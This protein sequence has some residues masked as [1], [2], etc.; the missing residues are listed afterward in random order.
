MANTKINSMTERMTVAMKSN[1]NVCSV[2]VE[3]LLRH[4]QS[5]G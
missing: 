3:N 1:I 5:V 4:Q 2:E